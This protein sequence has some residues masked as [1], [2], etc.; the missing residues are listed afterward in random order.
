MFLVTQPFIRALSNKEE[1]ITVRCLLC[2]STNHQITLDCLSHSKQV[3]H[4]EKNLNFVNLQKKKRNQ[5]NSH[6][7]VRECKFPNNNRFA[8]HRK[9]GESFY[10]SN[11]SQNKI[12]KIG[13]MLVTCVGFGPSFSM[14]IHPT[15]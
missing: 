13:K 10:S 14:L 11:R 7:A 1:I 2:R 15:S 12:L 3:G 4:D 5:K 8:K 6:R 9:K